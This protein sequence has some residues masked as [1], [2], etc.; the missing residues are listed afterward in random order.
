MQPIPIYGCDVIAGSNVDVGRGRGSGVVA[1][2]VIGVVVEDGV[3]GGPGALDHPWLT[4]LFFSRGVGVV[5][6]GFPFS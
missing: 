2:E 5:A 3:D 4:Y 6:A 1:G